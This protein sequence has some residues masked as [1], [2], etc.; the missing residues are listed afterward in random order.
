MEQSS[1]AR[2]MAQSKYTP[3][4]ENQWYIET[5][6]GLR[7]LTDDIM[8]KDFSRF[9]DEGGNMRMLTNVGGDVESNGQTGPTDNG[10]HKAEIEISRM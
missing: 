1:G 8:D 9:R 7:K 5:P 6:V 4:I 3:S 10:K 2:R